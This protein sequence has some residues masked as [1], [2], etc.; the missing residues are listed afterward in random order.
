MYT[1]A[2]ET[3]RSTGEVG[4]KCG[5]LVLFALQ[6]RHAAGISSNK[7][8][9]KERTQIKLRSVQVGQVHLHSPNRNDLL[10][11]QIVQVLFIKYT[12]SF[13]IFPFL[14]YL[15]YKVNSLLTT[16]EHALLLKGSLLCHS[17]T[18]SSQKPRVTFHLLRSLCLPMGN[19]INLNCI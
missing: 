15:F 10:P 7:K 14:F 12:I 1:A 9:N 8:G 3:N 2:T 18:L 4:K 5:L 6:T 16:S 13:S 11:G 19:R 17:S